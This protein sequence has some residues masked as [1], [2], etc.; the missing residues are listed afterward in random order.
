MDEKCIHARRGCARGS[1]R[2]KREGW[3]DVHL[4]DESRESLQQQNDEG[5]KREKKKGRCWMTSSSSG[6][7]L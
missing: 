3:K 7:S 6:V 1:A 4:G 5:R 2:G